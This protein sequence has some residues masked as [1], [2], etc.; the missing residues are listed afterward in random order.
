MPTYSD[1]VIEDWERTLHR[2]IKIVL[3]TDACTQSFYVVF[4]WGRGQGISYHPVSASQ[5][6]GL[7][8]YTSQANFVFFK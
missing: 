2:K 7:Q 5:M 8:E 6:L 3:P 1:I 4:I